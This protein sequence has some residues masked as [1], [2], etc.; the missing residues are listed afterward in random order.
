MMAD[1]CRALTTT[2]DKEIVMA[3]RTLPR[4]PKEQKQSSSLVETINEAEN[5][6]TG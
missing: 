2:T 5:I 6:S 3:T 1:H 4:S